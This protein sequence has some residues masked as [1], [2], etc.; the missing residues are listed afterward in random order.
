[1]LNNRTTLGN[2]SSQAFNKSIGMEESSVSTI[3]SKEDFHAMGEF[4]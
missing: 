4:N 2:S 1:M 3:K